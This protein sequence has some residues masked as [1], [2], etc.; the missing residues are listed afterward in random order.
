MMLVERAW[1]PDYDDDHLSQFTQ[2]LSD[3]HAKQH[4]ASGI[5]INRDV[6]WAKMTD[7]QAFIFLLQYPEYTAHFRPV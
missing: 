4:F 6:V 7:Q 3:F 5:D 1:H 2:R